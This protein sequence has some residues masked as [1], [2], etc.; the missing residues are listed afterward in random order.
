MQIRRGMTAVVTGAASGI[1]RG[2]ALA[3]ARRG[4]NVAL[5]DVDDEDGAA[6]LGEVRTHGVDAIYVHT[7]VRDVDAMHA[8][9]AAVRERFGD[10]HLLCNNAGFMVGGPLAA[11]TPEQWRDLLDVNVLGVVNGLLAFLPSMSAQQGERHVVNTASMS[12][13]RVFPETSA[14]VASKFAVL[15]LTEVLAAE[16]AAHG[17]G[18][19]AL[20]PAGVATRLAARQLQARPDAPR[21]A[22]MDPLE[23]G[24]RVVAG[25]EADAMYIVT[26]PEFLDAVRERHRRIEAAFGGGEVQAGL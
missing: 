20:C 19:S 10:T 17:C 9:A 12:A 15:G 23:V 8:L 22:L 2:I 13:L 21:Q 18:V 3:V 16:R 14:Y 11:S 4:M 5:A 24:R 25:V 26:H 7:D 1:G 6:A